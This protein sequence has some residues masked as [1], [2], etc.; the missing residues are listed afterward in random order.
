MVFHNVSSSAYCLILFVLEMLK[1]ASR[2]K[3][4]EGHLNNLL[5]IRWLFFGGGV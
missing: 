4:M 3:L 2:A 1:K 5:L